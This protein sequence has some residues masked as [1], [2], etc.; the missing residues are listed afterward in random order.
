MC[1]A[2]TFFEALINSHCGA[3]H[4]ICMQMLTRIAE[5]KYG[6]FYYSI[7]DAG[8]HVSD[9]NCKVLFRSIV[10]EYFLQAQRFLELWH[11]EL[12]PMKLL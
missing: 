1:L 5:V 12:G 2:L 3:K 7:G 11:V 4:L 9:E 6:V 10:A 8:H